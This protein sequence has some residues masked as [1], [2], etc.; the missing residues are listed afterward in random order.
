MEEWITRFTPHQLLNVLPQVVVEDGPEYLAVIS[1]PGMSLMTRDEPGRTRL[2]VEERIA[3]YLNPHL[4]QDWYERTVDH[5]AV[6]SLYQPG[7]AHSIRLFWDGAWQFQFWYVNLEDP[8]QRTEKGIRVNDLTLDIVITPDLQWSWKDEPEFE[9]LHQAGHFTN[10]RVEAIRAEGQRV[11]Q[12]LEAGL[13]PF[14]QPWPQWR[15]EPSWQ[16][17]QIQDYWQPELL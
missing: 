1:L 12:R 7:G 11:I 4:T 3:L 5:R 10:E 16:A 14:N 8:Y 2:S 17:P 9:A 15:P 13:W 6:L